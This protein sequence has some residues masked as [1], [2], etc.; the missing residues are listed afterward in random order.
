MTD[1][2]PSPPAYPND[3]D[4]PYF[5]TMYALA[6]DLA[7]RDGRPIPTR[8]EVL[9][10]IHEADPGDQLRIGEPYDPNGN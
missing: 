3:P 8:A 5:E 10:T 2:N 1:Q 9:A 4:A 6:C 7:Q